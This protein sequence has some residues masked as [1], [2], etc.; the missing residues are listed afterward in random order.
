MVTAT[1]PPASTTRAGTSPARTE[2]GAFLRSRRERLTPQRVGLPGGGRRRTPGLRREEVAMLAQVGVTWYTWLEQGRDINP[3]PEVLDAI[4][5]ALQLDHDERNH[6]WRLVTGH[7]PAPAGATS[8]CAVV[9]PGH[10]AL[11]SQV[12]PFPA[13]VQNARYDILASN[14]AYRF[15][16]TDLDDGPVENRNCLVRA[17]LDPDWAKAYRD[18]PAVTARMVARLRAG[19]AAHLDDPSWTRFV[20]RMQS[21]SP[22]FAELWQRGEI[23]SDGSSTTDFDLPRFGKVSFEFT[24]LWLDTA[25]TLHLSVL[26]PV[27]GTDT[28]VL[29][30]LSDFVADQPPVTT[31]PSVTATLS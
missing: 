29:G 21:E 6:L 30:P 24:R 20:E 14:A 12:M 16:I 13:C 28:G 8:G 18:Y 31:R 10:L 11:L 7:S 4:A 26:R 25:A 23:A 17:F 22:H 15:M 9:T 2:I 3:S 19:M 27:S 5:G 1:T